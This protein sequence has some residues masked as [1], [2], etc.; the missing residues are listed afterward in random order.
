MEEGNLSRISVS[1]GLIE[2]VKSFSPRLPGVLRRSSRTVRFLA[3]SRLILKSASAPIG[4]SVK[5]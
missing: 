1:E 4:S 5:R 3:S 2:A